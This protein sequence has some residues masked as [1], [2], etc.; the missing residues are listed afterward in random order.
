M[1]TTVMTMTMMSQIY[2]DEGR[3]AYEVVVVKNQVSSRK[4]GLRRTRLS[5]KRN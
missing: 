2:F 1:V 3:T 4:I 5:L